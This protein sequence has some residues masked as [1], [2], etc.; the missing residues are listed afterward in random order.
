[1]ALS[2]EVRLGK[3]HPSHQNLNAICNSPQQFSGS[4]VVGAQQQRGKGDLS[5][6]VRTNLPLPDVPLKMKNSL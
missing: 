2:R 5:T 1:M 3:G 4:G 6:N